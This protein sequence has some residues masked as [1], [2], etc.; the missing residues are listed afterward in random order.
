MRAGSMWGSLERGQRI[1]QRLR[2]AHSARQG[3]VHHRALSEKQY[4]WCQL[5]RHQ[6]LRE[7]IIG[8]KVQVLPWSAMVPELLQERQPTLAPEG[9]RS[10]GGKGEKGG[11]ILWCAGLRLGCGA[12]SLTLHNPRRQRQARV[13]GLHAG[14]LLVQ[15]RCK[16][17][18]R[19]S[20]RILGSVQCRG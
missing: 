11:Q 8:T 18:S 2:P 20:S 17:S 12:A 19:S 13:S 14:V 7:V 5:R 15:T 1:Q 3:K 4:Q 16:V 6:L 9:R 10:E